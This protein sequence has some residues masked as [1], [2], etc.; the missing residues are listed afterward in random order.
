MKNVKGIKKNVKKLTN[1]KVEGLDIDYGVVEAI[2]YKCLKVVYSKSGD[3]FVNDILTF[4]KSEVLEDLQQ[5]VVVAMLE[6]GYILNN[7]LKI[8]KHAFRCNGVKFR[9]LNKKYVYRTVNGCL[10]NY[11]KEN[12]KNMEIIVNENNRDNLENIAYL[13]FLKEKIA[14]V[15]H[16]TD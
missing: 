2:T 8:G 15:S 3:A 9:L 1:E 13:E 16:E 10:Y 5:A 11:R 6:S 7:V 12:V 4:R 14:T